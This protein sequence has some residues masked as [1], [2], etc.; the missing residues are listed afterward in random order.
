MEVQYL[1]IPYTNLYKFNLYKSQINF[2]KPCK[3]RV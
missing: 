3:T 1:K 2:H